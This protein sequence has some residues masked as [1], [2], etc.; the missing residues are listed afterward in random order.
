M[1]RGT[2][3][4]KVIAWES[5]NSFVKAFDGN[6][7]NLKI[8]P[9]TLTK[10]PIKSVNTGIFSGRDEDIVYEFDKIHRYN[11]GLTVDYETSSM[12]SVKRYEDMQFYR[13]SI[14]A[15]SQYINEFESDNIKAVTALPSVHYTDDVI[16]KLQKRFKGE[17]SLIIEKGNERTEINFTIGELHVILQPE[18]TFYYFL[19]D[20]K[21][22]IREQSLNRIKNS[23]TLVF[24]I[25]WGT[26]DTAEFYETKMVGFDELKGL[27]MRRVYQDILELVK[28]EFK[29]TYNVPLFEIERQ[30]RLTDGKILKFA[31]KEYQVEKIVDAV[32]TDYA[33]RFVRAL[34][35]K[36]ELGDYYTVLLTGGGFQ[37]LE[38]YIRPHLSVNGNWED[39]IFP[40]ANA[41]TTNVIGY[42]IYGAYI[43]K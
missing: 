22:K 39:N 35:G 28:D 36:Y 42:Y 14:I 21:G 33:E 40:F 7:E 27:S 4:T 15:L 11:V 31:N 32:Y 41:Q 10:A 26:T 12:S 3:P 16:E 13:E 37:T 8:Y 43:A 20:E 34:R 1:A 24:D 29:I 18:G 30:L 25:G 17:H 23:K 19:A 6:R 2:V 9:N 5:A 38:N